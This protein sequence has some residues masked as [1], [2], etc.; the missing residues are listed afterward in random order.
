MK[1][2][3]EN[4]Q[5]IYQI[6][7]AISGLI[8]LILSLSSNQFEN[9]GLSLVF[10]LF[11]AILVHFPTRLLYEEVNLIHLVALVALFVFTPANIT[12]TIALGIFGGYI[13]RWIIFEKRSWRRFLKA[14]PWL[15]IG[16]KIGII[17]IPIFV[18]SALISLF[19]FDQS[20][21]GGFSWTLII[22]SSMIFV[23]FHGLLLITGFGLQQPLTSNYH[24][25]HDFRVLIII[26]IL[27]MT[28]AVLTIGGY[29]QA[30][31]L[32]LWLFAGVT[33]TFAVL[34]SRLNAA[35]KDQIRRGRELSTLRRISSTLRSTIDL[36]KLLPV[37]QEQVMELLEVNNF[38]IA[39]YDRQHQELWYPIA[40]KSGEKQTWARREIS[41]RL[42]DRVI[43]E[44]K[45]ILLTP[46]TQS[47]LAPVGLP[48]SEA[49]P[50]AWLGVPLISSERTIGCLAVFKLEP[51]SS[52]SID[53]QDVLTTLSGQVSVAI[54]NALLY[55]KS[56]ERAQQL[57]TLNNLT[58]A[59]A[60]S[61]NL[62]EVLA[63]VC[64]SVSL[65]V[66][67]KRSAIF[68]LDHNG[69]TISLAHTHGMETPFKERNASF[70][71][72]Q[73]RRARCLRTGRP[74]IVP[75]IKDSSL[76]LDL[77]QHYRADKI[78]AF[79]DFP[80]VTPDGQ[81]GFLSIYFHQPHKFT[82][83]EI[84]I[85]QT[86]ASQAALAVANARLHGRT[87]AALAVRVNQL[88][89]LEA[90]GRELSAASHSERLYNLI[91]EYALEMTHSGCGT[92]AI[93]DLETQ[94]IEVKASQGFPLTNADFPINS[95]ITGR[96]AA[97]RQMANVPDVSKDPDYVDLRNGENHSLLS[98]PIIHENRILGVITLESTEY[99]AYS[100]SEEAFVTQL[101]I[102]AAINIVN[103]ELYH[104]TQR[105]L[106]EQSTLYQVSNRLVMATSP[107]HVSQTIIQAIE[108]ALHTFATGIYYWSDSQK[109]YH[110][111]GEQ[112]EHLPKQIDFHPVFEIKTD[113]DFK[114]L[115][116]NEIFNNLGEECAKCQIVGF[117]LE[118]SLGNPAIFVLHLPKALDL[119]ENET[120]LIRVIL[121]QG[122]IALQNAH[123]LQ[124]VTR[125][126]NRLSAI[127]NSIEEG[128]LMVDMDGNVL[129]ANEPIRLLTGLPLESF[130]D[131]PIQNLPSSTLKTIGYES[132][133]IQYLL[134]SL[135]QNV[136]PSASKT[137]VETNLAKGPQFFERITTPV[138]GQEDRVSGWMLLLRDITEE[139]ELEQTREA[140]TE[141]IVH[142]LRSP[143]S[144][145]VGALDLLSDCLNKPSEQ[146]L[147]NLVIEQSLLV[148]QRSANRVLDL[149]E[150]LLEI[151]RLQS[152]RMEINVE[153][154]NFPDMVS[155]LLDDFT[156]Q[157]NDD[158]VI[159]RAQIPTDLPPILADRS[160]LIRILTNL[161]DNAIKFTPEGEQ[162]VISAVTETAK[163]LTIQV[164]DAGPG[165]PED[166]REKIFER[167][168]QVPGQRPRRRGTGLGL[169]FCQLAVEAHGGNIWVETPEDGGSVFKFT[170]PLELQPQAA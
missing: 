77:I 94:K 123:Y 74:V 81:I 33:I 157:A 39:L 42:T 75:S 88:S 60:A 90:V 59:M 8:V 103:A 161:V 47:L 165:V 146:Q 115:K 135:N 64:N 53:D 149:T 155:D 141:T 18:V 129:L 128:I 1:P 110:L 169:T 112:N 70:S 38:Y 91:L 137:V 37:I 147:E 71:I 140:I 163:M 92:V 35:R 167:F 57:E 132:A 2:A 105:S 30:G 5:L 134:E 143:M 133:E 130:L 119:D 17:C 78:Q 127:I 16:Y 159:I 9:F 40:V 69:H 24:F 96:V 116:L 104:E 32:M 28:F 117:P 111:I 82:L 139:Y 100:E 68:L 102:Q 76:S 67:V 162:I 168:V 83:E 85:L 29:L 11:I 99:N 97:T 154:I 153:E 108:A 12:W 13:S 6:L 106:R 73:S 45:P 148:A 4:K 31:N 55:Q 79:G 152:G 136:I 48:K 138:W 156:A 43:K 58:G 66:G 72:A 131:A 26:E 113:S 62:E 109:K 80:L 164:K 52:F 36:D 46:E 49:T 125:G 145:I 120:R 7:I 44:E 23:F 22:I 107:Q 10:A 151:A 95:G 61:L 21:G 34:M 25:S 87:D 114:L 150:S 65:M 122:S 170:L 3:F 54:E 14:N 63:Q 160:K 15:K 56:Q 84:G 98:I 124:E 142:D 86:L 20:D 121:A 19:N 93:Y 27:T 118:M 50:T 41:Q 166:F 101:A 126:H 144:A 51:G 89:T 158:G